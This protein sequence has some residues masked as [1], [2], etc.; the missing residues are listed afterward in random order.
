M[1]ANALPGFPKAG[2]QM[3]SRHTLYSDKNTGKPVTKLQKTKRQDETET[4][5]PGQ[6]LKRTLDINGKSHRYRSGKALKSCGK[7]N[8]RH[9]VEISLR[10]GLEGPAVLRLGGERHTKLEQLDKGVGEVL[11]ESVTVLS[12]T[13]HVL[14]EFLVLHEG[15]VG[16]KHHQG[17]GGVVSVLGRTVPLSPRPLLLKQESEELVGEDRGAEVPRTL[18]T[19]AVPVCTTQGVGTDE[20]D[21]LAVIEAHASEN[22]ADMLL[23]LGSVRETSVRGAGG[24]ILVLTAGSPGDRRALHLLDGT[25]TGK[26]PEVG[27]GDP[28]ELLYHIG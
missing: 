13:L 15:N 24:E 26:G 28:W 5:R 16:R 17:L 23:V 11:E 18:V 2:I 21:H 19:R 22:V 27:V 10:A 6:N 12:V 7:N 9:Y 3:R 20:G 25:D 14:P 8:Q 4:G 1:A